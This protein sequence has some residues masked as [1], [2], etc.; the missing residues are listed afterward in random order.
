[1]NKKFILN[2]LL[3]IFLFS[4]SSLNIKAQDNSLF[5]VNNRIKFG[6]SLFCEEDYYRAVDEYIEALKEVNN[7]TLRFKVAYSLMKMGRYAEAEDYYKGLFFNSTLEEE[8]RFGFYQSSFFR[9]DYK[10]FRDLVTSERYM[11]ENR[12]HAIYRLYYASQYLQEN[13]L[14]DTNEV[15]KVFAGKY[16]QSLMQ[17]Y[18]NKANPEYKSP[19]TA[20]ILSTVI[21]GAGKVYTGNYMDGIFSFILNGLFIWLA[22]DNFDNNRNERGVYMS[23]IWGFLYAGN[24]YGSAASAQNYNAGIRFNFNND[25]DIF[26]KENNYFIPQHNY[27]RW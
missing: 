12:K 5:S 21:P 26:F 25:I 2:S 9:R 10:A 14:P 18:R 3:I 24:I 22:Y 6:N 19:W 17:L 8:A 13:M 4:I 11:P 7:D 27:C 15:K 16:H 1:M 23:L 20:A